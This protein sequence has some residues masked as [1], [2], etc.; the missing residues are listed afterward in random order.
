MQTYTITDLQFRVY[1]K[2]IHFKA[3]LNRYIDDYIMLIML[4]AFNYDQNMLYRKKK[5]EAVIR[6]ADR[7]ENKQ[8][9]FFA[10]SY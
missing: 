5:H 3:Q 10:Y 6:T 2:L 8:V 9:L 7:N 4:S 1:T